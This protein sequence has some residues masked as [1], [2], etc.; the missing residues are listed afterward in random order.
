M[1]L[2]YGHSKFA[3]EFGGHDGEVQ[4]TNQYTVM[5]E[6]SEQPKWSTQVPKLQGASTFSMPGEEPG[7]FQNNY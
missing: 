6:A 3:I 7:Q 1:Q 2:N 5:R 4:A